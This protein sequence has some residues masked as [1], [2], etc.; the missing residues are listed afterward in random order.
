MAWKFIKK[1]CDMYKRETWCA[2]EINNQQTCL[3]EIQLSLHASRRKAPKHEIW[4]HAMVGDFSPY[5]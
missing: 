2:E 1:E 5:V 4:R 3:Q